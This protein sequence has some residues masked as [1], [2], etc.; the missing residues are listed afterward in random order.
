VEDKNFYEHDHAPFS[1][2]G[3]RVILDAITDENPEL[4]P[5]TPFIKI[6]VY[7]DG[8]SSGFPITVEGTIRE[9]RIEDGRLI[10]EVYEEKSYPKKEDIDG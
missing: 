3:V 7:G 2:N 1:L 8:K 6:D 9:I 5:T 4:E 10:F